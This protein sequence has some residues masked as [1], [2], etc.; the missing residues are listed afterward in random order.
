MTGDPADPRRIRVLP[1]RVAAL[2]VFA[3]GVGA[4]A[5]ASARGA[6]EPPVQTRQG[7]V[8]VPKPVDPGMARPA[9]AMP[10]QSTPVIKPD[11]LRHGSKRGVVTEEPR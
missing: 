7:M 10:A 4:G 11:D 1:G 5:Q 6:T 8:R 3:G 9:P 2:L